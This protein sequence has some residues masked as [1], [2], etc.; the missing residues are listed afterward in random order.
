[1]IETYNI[2]LRKAKKPFNVDVFD[3]YNSDKKGVIVHNEED[4]V[5]E[6]EWDEIRDEISG[7]VKLSSVGMWFEHFTKHDFHYWEQ[8]TCS[9]D[10][11]QRTKWCEDEVR[12]LYE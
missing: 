5:C 12:G 7:Y 4:C 1:M 3:L 10:G 6:K 9:K 2:Y 11:Y 8:L